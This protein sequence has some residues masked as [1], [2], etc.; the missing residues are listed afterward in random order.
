MKHRPWGGYLLAAIGVL[1]MLFEV[2]L[3]YYGYLHH[4]D[5]ELNHPVLYV[6]VLMG[7]VGFYMINPKSAEGGADIITKSVV[8]IISVVRSGKRAGDSVAVQVTPV[9]DGKPDTA[10]TAEIAIPNP[11]SAADDPSTAAILAAEAAARREK[12]ELAPPTLGEG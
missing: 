4:T 7:F 5:Y 6:A 1:V 9:T 3:H 11:P 10:S 8:A 2:S 12:H